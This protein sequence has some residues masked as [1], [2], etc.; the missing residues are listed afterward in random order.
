MLETLEAQLHF[1]RKI[2]E[3]D[4]EGVEPLESIRDETSE[5]QKRREI[6]VGTLKAEF[7]KEEVVGK[8]GR[9]RRRSGLETVD[10][11]SEDE[12][13]WNVLGQAGKK[14]GRYFV[15]ETDKD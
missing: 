8:R 4:T 11:R 1:V 2:R 12:K 3:V 15:V 5:G 10:A 6:G 13:N 9:I 14:S 7:A